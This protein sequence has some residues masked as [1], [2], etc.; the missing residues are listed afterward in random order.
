[1]PAEGTR[2]A[3]LWERE[4]GRLRPKRFANAFMASR[5]FVQ[6]LGIQKRLREHRGCVNTV[7]F[8]SSGSLLLSG[9]DDMTLVLWDWEAGTPATSLHTGHENNVLHAQFMPSSGDRSIVTAGA[10][11]EVRHLQM[12]EGGPVVV[13]RFVELEYPVHR[14]AVEPG[15]PHTFYSCGGDGSVWHFDLRGKEATKLFSC[16]SINDKTTKIIEL[17]AVAM[18]PRNPCYFALSGSDEYVRLYDRRKSFVNGGSLFGTPVEHFC[19]PHLIG[20]NK[21]GITGLAFS[22]AGEMLASYSYDNIYLFEREHGLHFNNFKV[23]EKL[24]MDETMGATLPQTFKGHQNMQTVKGVNFLGPNYDFVASGSDCGYVFI[25]RKKG[26]ELIRVMKGDKRIVNCVEQH[27]SESIFA[28]SGID[29]SIKIWG[30]GGSED[31]S[32]ANFDEVDDPDPYL[33]SM[34]SDSDSSEYMDDYIFAPVSGSSSD[35]EDEDDDSSGED[36]TS[37]DEG[38]TE[39]MAEG[40]ESE[41]EEDA[42]E[43]VDGDEV[44]EEEVDK[45]GDGDMDDE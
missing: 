28:S 8:N 37:S 31:P 45:G 14:L 22:Q 1:M 27:P 29:T 5:D 17:Y 3:G 18:D 43:M 13:D 7:S 24:L 42:E 9:S 33:F 11:G 32:V 40:D 36:T 16:P 10:D 15:S 20:Q 26:G 21:D 30:A 12:R 25:W 44:V 34:S 41:E 38:D 2:M 6:S 4:V 23:G 19:P 39:E 35:G